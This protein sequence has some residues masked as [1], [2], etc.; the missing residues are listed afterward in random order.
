MLFKPQIF[1]KLF[2]S[3]NFVFI[4]Y[5]NDLLKQTASETLQFGQFAGNKIINLGTH[6]TCKI[7]LLNRD[8]IV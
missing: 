3:R 4:L 7:I 6:K 2:G 8:L 1:L 5:T